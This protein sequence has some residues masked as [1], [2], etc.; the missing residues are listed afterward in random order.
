MKLKFMPAAMLLLLVGCSNALDDYIQPPKLQ[1]V[2]AGVAGLPMAKTASFVPK[3]SSNQ[4]VPTW[5]GQAA[6][7]FRD[8]RAKKAGDVLTVAISIDDRASLNSNI[9][10]SRKSNIGSGFDLALDWLGLAHSG[11]GGLD[12]NTD[13]SAT[14]NGSVSRSERIELSVAAIVT[15]VLPNGH[16]VISG[17]Q[18]IRVNFE[19]RE[20]T[21]VGIVD[22]L[23]VAS[24]NT[25]S[26]DK[27]AE[28]RISYG[29]RGRV[30]DVQKP[31]FGQQ[32]FDRYTPF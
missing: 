7:L 31:G 6:D 22:P 8:R 29:G 4:V 30:M 13:S 18:E 23:H 20:L 9:D 16:M 32:L 24:N 27:I 17:S 10:R 5:E 19:I 21:V 11:S 26:Y 2:G 25:I 14:G 28:A 12:A 1:P 3:T 15:G